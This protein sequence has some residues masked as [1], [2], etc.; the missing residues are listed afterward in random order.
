VADEHMHNW[1][2]APSQ[3]HTRCAHSTSL[4]PHSAAKSVMPACQLRRM[5][6][7]PPI[8]VVE[9]AAGV[10]RQHFTTLLVAGQ[11][12][13]FVVARR[14]AVAASCL[15]AT[16]AQIV[17]SRHLIRPLSRVAARSRAPTS[18]RHATA[19][20]HSAKASVVWY[21]KV[22]ALWVVAMLRAPGAWRCA[23]STAVVHSAHTAAARRRT[24]SLAHASLSAEQTAVWV[25]VPHAVPHTHPVSLAP[26]T[27]VTT[28]GTAAA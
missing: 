13:R 24:A 1:P 15:W 18:R 19:M 14:S 22:R 6:P 28:T 11:A 23:G 3:P 16:L 4:F 9:A 8:R 21:R 20:T 5:W 27:A 26:G 7:I 10:K 17:A 25:D 12:L 2:C